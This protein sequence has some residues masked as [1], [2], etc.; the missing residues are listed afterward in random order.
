MP[1]ATAKA[2]FGRRQRA[3]RDGRGVKLISLGLRSLLERRVSGGGEGGSAV[4]NQLGVGRKHEDRHPIIAAIDSGRRRLVVRKGILEHLEDHLGVVSHQR[5]PRGVKRCLER[6]LLAGSPCLLA[7]RCLLG[8]LDGALPGGPAL[9]ALE[10]RDAF[11]LAVLVLPV[12]ERSVDGLGRWRHRRRGGGKLLQVSAQQAL[13]KVD[14]RLDLLLALKTPYL[15]LIS[16]KRRV[17]PAGRPP[18]PA[19]TRVVREG[20][21]ARGEPHLAGANVNACGPRS[22][23][24]PDAAA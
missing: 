13:L 16:R 15:S 7:G 1:G 9:G 19:A 10:H 4:G 6:P 3:R 24:G 17:R 23:A 22:D 8:T 18:W 12:N 5:L 2:S 21:D 14:N 11:K 20:P